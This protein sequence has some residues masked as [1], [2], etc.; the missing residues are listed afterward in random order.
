MDNT[1][2]IIT[3][4]AKETQEVGER[5]AIDILNNSSLPRIV[6]LYGELGA[7][8]TVLAQGFAKGLGL[9]SRMVSPTFII[10]KRYSLKNDT[11]YFYHVDL[12]RLQKIEDVE[13]LGLNELFADKDAIVVIEWADRLGTHVP[14]S[15]IDVHL[16]TISDE[17][18]KITYEQ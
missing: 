7:G 4:N 10:V 3:K 17:E 12:Y 2:T 9:P 14:K 13:A 1:Q 11:Q 16:K 15:R 6:C 5:L 18:R 8:K